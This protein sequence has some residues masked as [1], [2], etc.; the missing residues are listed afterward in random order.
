MGRRWIGVVEAH[1]HD[2]GRRWLA[3][4]CAAEENRTFAD[5]LHSTRIR[6]SIVDI[7]CRENSGSWRSCGWLGRFSL[8]TMK[9]QEAVDGYFEASHGSLAEVFVRSASL[10]VAYMDD[11]VQENESEHADHV[12]E[13]APAN[14]SNLHMDR[15]VAVEPF[16]VHLAATHPAYSIP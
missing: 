8:L 1:S 12:L 16:D 2:E 11:S 5:R 14:S 7:H 9:D 13:L 10:D 15:R 3:S 6:A 4:G